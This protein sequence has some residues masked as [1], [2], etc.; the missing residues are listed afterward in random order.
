MITEAKTPQVFTAITWNCEGIGNSIFALKE[1]LE[2][3]SPDFAFLS[4]SQIFSADLEMTMSVLGDSYCWYLNSDD[5]HDRDLVLTR[6]RSLGGTLLLWRKSLDP[7]ISI[8]QVDTPAFTPILFQ[9]PGYQT[10]IHIGLY[11]PTSG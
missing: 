9:Q 1:M 11:L 5:M 3:F 6:T 8:Q 2:R 10:S 4:E 7:Y